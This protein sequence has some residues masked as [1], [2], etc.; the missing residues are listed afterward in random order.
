MEEETADQMRERIKVR[1]E[2]AEKESQRNYAEERVIRRNIRIARKRN[3]E[4]MKT[5]SEISSLIKFLEKNDVG[6]LEPGPYTVW[7]V[8]KWVLDDE[9]EEGHVGGGGV[10]IRGKFVSLKGDF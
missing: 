2:K 8:L 10:W 7:S 5:K 6:T 9:D 4:N 3:K 1:T